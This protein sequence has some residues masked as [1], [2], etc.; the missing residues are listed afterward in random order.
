MRIS[1]IKLKMTTFYKSLLR[2]SSATTNKSVFELENNGNLAERPDFVANEE[3]VLEYWS[4][5]DAF[6]QQL[7]KTKHLPEYTFYDGPPFATGTPH[8]GH[9]CAGTIKDVVTRYA[10]MNGY[11]VT[12]RF[13]WD[14]HGLPVEHIVDQEM[15]IETRKEIEVMGVDKYNAACRSIV[16]RYSSQWRE[17]V[18][19]L[20]RWIDF[21]NDYKTM[22]RDFMESVWWVFNEIFKQGLVYRG[23][24]VMPYS[25][26]CSTVL[27]NFEANLNYKDVSDPSIIVTFPLTD[28]PDVSF[29]AWTTTPWTLP[30]NLALTVN[31]TMEYVRVK[32][33]KTNKVFILAKCRLG[34]IFKS[35]KGLFEIN[36]N[37]EERKPIDK[38]KK[39]TKKK[40]DKTDSKPV[41]V[42]VTE[43]QE[44]EKES[45]EEVKEFEILA[46][47]LGS[48]L[49]GK[50]Y[51]PLFNYYEAKM[52]PKGCFKVLCGSFVTSDSGTGIVHTAPAFGDE[53]YKI[54]VKAGVIEP[55][56][57]CI[58]I[59]ENGF[60]LPEITHFAGKYIK[61]AEKDVIKHLQSAHR[62]LKLGSEVHSYPFCWR[63]N[64]PLIYKAVTT[65]FIK[66]SAVRERLLKN[67]KQSVWVP[68]WAQEKRF[69]NWLEGAEDWCFSRN[70]FWGNPIPI[71]ASEDGE[72]I[73]CI[74]STEELKK[75]A[76]LPDTYEVKDL[77]REFIDHIT[78][79]SKRG[80]GQLKRIEEVFDCW[81]ESGSM[82]YASVGY[83]FKTSPEKFQ[84]M[85]PAN[86]IGE[87]L[88]QTR[89][90]FYTL[91]VIG[92]LLFDKCP[93]QNL[94]VNG[95]VLNEQGEKL[96]KSKKNFPDPW[97]MIKKAGSDPLRLYLMNSPLVRGEN[98]KFS[99]SHLVALV[100]DIF[101]PWYNVTRLFLQEAFRFNRTFGKPFQFKDFENSDN[102]L[103]KWLLAKT[104][105]LVEYVKEEMNNY[106]LY[107][108]LEAK[109]RFLNDLSNWYVKLNKLRL[110]GETSIDDCETCLS[111]LLHALLTSVTT[112]AP[113]VPFISEYL[114]QYLRQ[115]LP[116]GHALRTES[117]HFLRIPTVN[118]T[119][120]DSSL[121]KGIEVFQSAI[122][123][124]RAARETRKV[125]LKQPILKLTVRPRDRYMLP[126]F[127]LLEQYFREETNVV[128][129]SFASDYDSFVMFDLQPNF[130]TLNEKLPG[131]LAKLRPI[132][133]ALTSSQKE[134]FIK[135][136]VLH[137]EVDGQKL[138]LDSECLIAVPKIIAKPSSESLMIVG[139]RECS[140][141]IDFTITERLK[142]LG[143]AREVTNRI[144][145]FRKNM[146]FAIEDKICVVLAA[147]KKKGVLD[148]VFEKELEFIQKV[149]KKPVFVSDSNFLVLGSP[150]AKSSFEVEGE[151]FELKIHLGGLVL[152]LDEI[153]SLLEEL[154][155]ASMNS[156]ISCLTSVDGIALDREGSSEIVLQLQG[157]K[158]VLTRNKHFV[159]C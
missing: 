100:K 60:Y 72:E 6:G 95:I 131:M 61:D 140:L 38:K 31:P 106:R 70:R 91:N 62:V 75:L 144:Q 114:Y 107:T 113:F 138:A 116:E 84:T 135:S 158:L 141:E 129:V 37:V 105:S 1:L 22:D 104:N 32:D 142:L 52:K 5:I 115:F 119:F 143:L 117:V 134:E 111:L 147:A 93:Y 120:N 13:G 154:N 46:T 152:K 45:S 98:L 146:K 148:E 34:E 150:I 97:I 78:I 15:K 128:D 56:D 90:W 27:S 155:L 149:V 156:L 123:A 33:V 103:D 8:Y 94:I 133:A 153:K 77:H 73:V 86:F 43:H 28:E 12:R 145:K 49:E 66:V 81:F 88:D 20:G 87:G 63:S 76:G 23:C 101:L 139:D 71:W 3:K 40:N 53:D 57:P 30:T 9:I 125:N 79:P 74:G 41:D 4:K 2:M 110:K 89:G 80:K 39:D 159:I 54:C 58:S 124:A 157:R 83:P 136:Q 17:M 132:I 92:T 29:L 26:G 108:V 102:V 109:L 10:S 126:L 96:S 7:E 151:S 118:P 35:A 21:D 137:V 42:S 64:T 51:V 121:I 99:E 130:K 55:S 68:Q 18:G 16:M 11:H 25:N 24:R 47:F 127:N 36:A 50:S 85:F 44:T 48:A 14:C 69:N 82:P 65:W 59:N 122:T 19:R 112:F 67:N